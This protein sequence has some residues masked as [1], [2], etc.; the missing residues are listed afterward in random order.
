M[1]REQERQ[2][3]WGAREEKLLVLIGQ[4][5]ETLLE[6]MT[7]A[8]K[9][10][11]PKPPPDGEVKETPPEA[12]PYSGV[13]M[14]QENVKDWTFEEIPDEGRGMTGGVY[15]GDKTV[16]GPDGISM[17]PGTPGYPFAAPVE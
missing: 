13:W 2:E 7:E 9:E 8:V 17:I 4:R 3:A 10:L 5:D 6:A 11:L 16:G 1:K 15:A 14:G 12:D